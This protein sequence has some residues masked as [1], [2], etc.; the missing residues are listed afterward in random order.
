MA[1]EGRGFILVHCGKIASAMAFDDVHMAYR[2]TTTIGEFDKRLGETIKALC[3]EY[4]PL[5]EAL[6]AIIID[7]GEDPYIKTTLK[8]NC[9]RSINS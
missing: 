1:K 7:D 4:D 5:T 2:T 6:V 3:E 8:L 9:G